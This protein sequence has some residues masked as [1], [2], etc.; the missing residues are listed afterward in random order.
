MIGASVSFFA[1]MSIIFSTVFQTGMS[2]GLAG[3]SLS[4]ALMFTESLLWLVRAHAMMEMSMNS[5]E[6]LEEYLDLEEEAPDIIQHSR[7]PPNVS[8]CIALFAP[9]F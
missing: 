8:R 3:L 1:G 9:F 4:Y 6:R 2:A 5:M 7:P